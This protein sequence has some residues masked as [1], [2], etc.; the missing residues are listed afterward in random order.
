ML[1][2]SLRSVFA[3][4]A[5]VAG[6][7]FAT[8][9]YSPLVSTI[10]ATGLLV[11]IVV[12]GIGAASLR[13]SPRV[14]CSGF[15]ATALICTWIA[16]GSL[17]DSFTNTL[18]THRVV[19]WVFEGLHGREIN[20]AY[21]AGDRDASP[22]V[23]RTIRFADGT[24]AIWDRGRHAYVTDDGAAI[25]PLEVFRTIGHCLIAMLLGS[26]GGTTAV[27]VSLV[28]EQRRRRDSRQSVL[29]ARSEAEPR[30]EEG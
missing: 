13:G 25:I 18:A 9:N 29:A 16:F 5:L 7:L 8:I 12:A 21:L 19:D 22:Y 20:D 27:V 26:A 2:F 1:R 23:E 15:A 11:A 14:F 4:V 10:C 3:L 28:S 17:D 6:A 24:I 30:N